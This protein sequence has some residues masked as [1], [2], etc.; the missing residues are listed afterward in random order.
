MFAKAPQ[1]F[2]QL[3]PRQPARPGLRTKVPGGQ[4]RRPLSAGWCAPSVDS[5]GAG[6]P[7]RHKERKMSGI[8]VGVDGSGHYGDMAVYAHDPARTEDAGAA[9]QAETDKVLAG[10]DGPHPESVTVK[11]VRGFVVE[12]L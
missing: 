8:I 9:A 6:K 7:L 12:E 2:C 1:A 10:L 11:A 3:K 4:P 5:R